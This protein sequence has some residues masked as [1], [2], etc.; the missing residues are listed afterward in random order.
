MMANRLPTL[1]ELNDT[2]FVTIEQV[3]ASLENFYNNKVR[4]QKELEAALS[5]ARKIIKPLLAF[6]ALDHLDGTG[7]TPEQ[8]RA[9][10]KW[11]KENPDI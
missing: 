3:Y 7:I 10:A 5:E 4:V 2:G 9:A 8:L 6:Y 1:K 11:L